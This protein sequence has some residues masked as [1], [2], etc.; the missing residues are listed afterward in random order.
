VEC[1]VPVNRQKASGRALLL[2]PPR[3]S[4]APCGK[5]PAP[6]TDELKQEITRLT[7]RLEEIERTQKTGAAQQ[8]AQ[9]PAQEKQNKEILSRIEELEKTQ[10]DLIEAI[11]K[12]ETTA[13]AAAAVATDPTSLLEQGKHSLEQKDF[14]TAIE[15][16]SLFIKS[17]SQNKEDAY[18][19]RGEAYYHTQQ[20]KKAIV[21]FSKFPE[22]YQKSKWMPSSLLR[23][24]QS[25]EALGMKEDAK[26]FYQELKD[27]FPKSKEAKSLPN[28]KKK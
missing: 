16:L 15:T 4:P 23:I 17:K 19:Y 26:G 6:A 10:A 9:A 27:K 11:K 21:D 28:S 5:S 2:A 14:P 25:F 24:G 1:V 12:L 7:A 3:A 8:S 18:F 13:T 20:F 22:K